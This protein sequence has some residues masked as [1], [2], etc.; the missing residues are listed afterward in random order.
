VG[1][2]DKEETGND[3]K[4]AVTLFFRGLSWYM[5]KV[6]KETHINLPEYQH[7]AII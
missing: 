4:E 1:R 6:S 7:S 5:S 2:E 3:W